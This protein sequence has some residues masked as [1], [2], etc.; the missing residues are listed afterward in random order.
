MNTHK[1]I[2]AETCDQI[3]TETFPKKITPEKREE[4]KQSLT[5]DTLELSR[6]KKSLDDIKADYKNE[7]KPFQERLKKTIET[8]KAGQEMVT[9]PVYVVINPNE[10][11][12]QF[13]DPDDGEIVLERTSTPAELNGTIFQAQRTGTDN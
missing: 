9:K 13:I 7:M 5:D 4:F 10:R 2:T 11:I 8:L 6:L 12:T 3:R 1:N